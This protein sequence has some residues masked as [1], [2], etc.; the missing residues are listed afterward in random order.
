MFKRVAIFNRKLRDEIFELLD[1][2]LHIRQSSIQ[3]F[4]FIFFSM[5]NK[6]RVFLDKIGSLGSMFFKESLRVLEFL[7]SEM[8]HSSMGFESMK[9]GFVLV[10]RSVHS[11]FIKPIFSFLNMIQDYLFLFRIEEFQMST[12][13]KELS[14]F[15]GK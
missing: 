12:I 11:L 5:R 2:F 15:I 9:L 14:R 7:L 3:K 8:D 4:N 13:I 1:V 10:L 6:M